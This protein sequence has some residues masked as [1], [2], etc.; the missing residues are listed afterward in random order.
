MRIPITLTVL[1]ACNPAARASEWVLAAHSRD[2]SEKMFVDV[3]SIRIIG[4]VRHVWDK[5]VPKPNTM[6]GTGENAKKPITYELSK[7]AFNCSDETEK[8]ESV[9]VYYDD[10]TNE[11]LMPEALS[12]R[13]EPIPPDSVLSDEMHFVCAWKLK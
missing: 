1:L 3:S 6:K 2:H 13:W 5:L 12:K 7:S 4:D 9:V 8:S 11:S 10:G